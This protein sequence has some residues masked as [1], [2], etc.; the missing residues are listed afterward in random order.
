MFVAT[1]AFVCAI[2]KSY[3]DE[4]KFNHLAVQNDG[5]REQNDRLA[6]LITD[7]ISIS[8]EASIKGLAGANPSKDSL[9]THVRNA[10]KG[11][12]FKV[13][14]RREAVDTDCFYQLIDAFPDEPKPVPLK[15]GANTFRRRIKFGSSAQQFEE[16]WEVEPPRDGDL[17]YNVHFNKGA[18]GLS[19]NLNISKAVLAVKLTHNADGTPYACKLDRC[20]LVFSAS[21]ISKYSKN[22]S[23]KSILGLKRLA[24]LEFF[25][26]R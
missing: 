6:N 23:S 25:S 21:S 7:E 2:L 15:S 11:Q 24:C 1:V 9:F 13:T 19:G 22:I 4:K 12:R 10:K 18:Q 17:I 20:C 26:M 16:S 5:L 14:L 3:G 8:S